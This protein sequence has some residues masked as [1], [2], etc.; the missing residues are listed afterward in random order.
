ML[1]N[2][3]SNVSEITEDERRTLSE[4][5]M[6]MCPSCKSAPMTA[7]E[8]QGHLEYYCRPCHYS[9]IVTKK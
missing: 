3:R 1:N 8:G 9:V 4:Q 2:T 7:L 6:L 5:G